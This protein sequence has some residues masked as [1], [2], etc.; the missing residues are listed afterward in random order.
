MFKIKHGQEQSVV[1]F[2]FQLRTVTRDAP[3]SHIFIF[4]DQKLFKHIAQIQAYFSSLFSLF[5]LQDL[6][7]V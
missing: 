7:K 4:L 5:Q 3:F 2:N 1:V 6:E